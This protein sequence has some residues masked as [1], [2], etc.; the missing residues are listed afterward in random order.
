MLF[1]RAALTQ[2]MRITNA[3]RSLVAQTL[4]ERG[5][6]KSALAKKMG[7]DRSWMTRFFKTTGG[8]QKMN[9]DLRSK[10][11]EILEIELFSTIEKGPA[12]A[13]ALKIDSE[14]DKDPRLSE[15]LAL[16][17]SAFNDDRFHDLPT[18]TDGDMVEFGKAVIR[19][20]AGNVDQPEKAGGLVFSWLAERLKAL[21]EN[22]PHGEAARKKSLLKK[23]KEEQR[24]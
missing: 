12:S 14:M 24:A 10:L 22:P 9:N 23:A 6:K 18:L 16:L 1:E 20:S 3:T 21:G 13:L 15:S 5:L 7:V 2:E 17:V 8:M 11:E 19:S 4:R